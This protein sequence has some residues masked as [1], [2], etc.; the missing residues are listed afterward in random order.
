MK[1]FKELKESAKAI[2]EAIK[3]EG[4]EQKLYVE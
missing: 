1:E 3:T 2:F 4:G